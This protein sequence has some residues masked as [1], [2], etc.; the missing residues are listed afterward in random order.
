MLMMTMMMMVVDASSTAAIEHGLDVLPGV[1]NVLPGVQSCVDVERRR[2]RGGT[3]GSDQFE[4]TSPRVEVGRVRVIVGAGGGGGGRVGGGG[5]VIVEDELVGR[6]ERVTVAAADTLGSRAR[7]PHAHE[8]TYSTHPCTRFG[9]FH[10]R[11]G[12]YRI[13]PARETASAV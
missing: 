11:R 9:H 2:R 6:E 5:A 13:L 3:G 1:L 10:R 8:S 4:V 7:T 12:T